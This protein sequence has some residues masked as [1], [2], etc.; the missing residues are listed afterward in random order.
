MMIEC[1]KHGRKLLLIAALAVL[2][3]CQT[4]EAKAR[5]EMIRVERPRLVVL[6]DIGGDPDDQQSMIRLLLYVN[7]Y[8]IEGLIATATRNR[9]SPHQIRERVEA[10]RKARPNLVKH[11]WG[12]PTADYLLEQIKAGVKGRS[13][14]LVGAG[15]STEASEYIISVVDRPEARPVWITV[16]GAPTDLAQ[17]L[18]DVRDRRSRVDVAKFVSK[19]RVY[20]IAGQDNTGAW[21]CHTFP[22]IFWVRSVDQFQAISVREASPFPPEVTGAN[23]ETFTTE[24]IDEHVQ[25]RGPLGR[26]YPERRWKYEGDTPAFLYLLRNGLSAPEHPH[27]GGW[28]GRFSRE[29]TKNPACAWP[30]LTKTQTNYYDFWAYADAEDTWSYKDITYANSHYASLFRWREAFQNDFA[31]RMDWSITDSY[32]KANHN[33]VAGFDNDTSKDIVKMRV[34]SGQNA[35]LSAAGSNDPD[36]DGLSFGW[37]Y[38]KE[39]GDYEGII[40]IR[41]SNARKASFTAPEVD[42]NKE[43]HII[44]EVKDDGEP[45]LYSYR[46][47]IV[48]VKPR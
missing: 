46:R 5:V 3:Q 26:L 28:G 47:V 24:W 19:L 2:A 15:K 45:S 39:P 17:A 10:Y 23:I 43:I 38:Y 31:A 29:K 18:W 16:W 8:Q 35:T 1:I 27:Y 13:M 11:A 21:I 6:T 4:G 25:S 12:Y 37:F 33:P 48:T 36:D 42:K 9:V 41:N 44:L 7:E 40:N 14:A 32:A 30:R 22:E 20:D 34:S